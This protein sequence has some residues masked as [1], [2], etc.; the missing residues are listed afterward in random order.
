MKEDQIKNFKTALLKEKNISYEFR[1][2]Y[3]TLKIMVIQGKFGN[4]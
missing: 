3:E 2:K 4:A 1:C